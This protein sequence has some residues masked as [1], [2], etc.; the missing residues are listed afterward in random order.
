MGGLGRPTRTG[1]RPGERRDG[2]DDLAVSAPYFTSGNQ[3]NEGRVYIFYQDDEPWTMLDEGCSVCNAVDADVKIVGDAK[4]SFGFAMAS[5][6]FDG[7]VVGGVLSLD[8]YHAR[9]PPDGRVVKQ[10]RLYNALDEVYEIIPP[11]DVGQ[12]VGE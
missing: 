7:E 5:G 4:N 3:D 10:Q 8:S 11:A 12:L 2:R 9:D 1:K 6:D